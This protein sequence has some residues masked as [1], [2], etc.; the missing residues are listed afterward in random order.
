[1]PPFLAVVIVFLMLPGLTAANQ[2]IAWVMVEAAAPIV[3]NNVEQAREA[4]IEIAEWKAIEEAVVVNISMETLLVNLK[5]SGSMVGAIPYAEIVE[6]EIIEENDGGQSG[7]QA[8]SSPM[9]RIKMKAGVVEKFE[10]HDP[11]FQIEAALNR[12]NFSNGQEMEISL[13]TTKECFYCIFILL[14]DQ[15]V[16]KLIPNQYRTNN[17]LESNKAYTIPDA[18][19]REKGIVLKVYTP[20]DKIVAKEAVY[21]LALQQPFDF[22]NADIQE[23]VFGIYNG[24]TAFIEDL[25]RQIVGIPLGDRAE[26][27]IQYQISKAAA[28]EAG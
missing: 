18:G 28:G 1:M 19:D 14:E 8:T 9:Y 16:L 27:L 26:Q 6:S 22:D 20:P 24:Q 15:K 7:N 23:G 21:V 3:G 2:D 11:S 12:T 10:G 13:K 17:F 5:L 25:I 4:A